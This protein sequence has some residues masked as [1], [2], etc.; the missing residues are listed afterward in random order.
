[1]NGPKVWVAGEE[2]DDGVIVTDAATGNEVVIRGAEVK[3]KRGTSRFG[4][5][6][7]IP[8]VQGRQV[9][10]DGK[11]ILVKFPNGQT[12]KVKPE[13]EPAPESAA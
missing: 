12:I 13:E 6:I 9:G 7:T 11:Y 8:T 4:R 1:M 3:A 5:P 10:A 2:C